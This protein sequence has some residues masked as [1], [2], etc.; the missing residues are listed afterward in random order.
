MS[1]SITKKDLYLPFIATAA[2]IILD[3]ITKILIAA[4][5]PEFTIGASY[6]NEFLRI[7][8]VRNL[9]VA[10]SFG[11]S[12]PPVLRRIFFSA[13]PLIVMGIVVRIYLKSK[14]F[15]KLQRWSICTV[16]GGGLGNIIDR[17]FRA[18]GVIDFIDVKFYGLFGMERWP[19]FNVADIAVVVGVIILLISFIITN[20]KSEEK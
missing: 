3:Q 2:V 6:L 18:D 1:N 7:V 5:L 9:G 12:W 19:T 10:F 11:Y 15:T 4:W 17:I 20:K 14:D 16:L 13:I 8:H